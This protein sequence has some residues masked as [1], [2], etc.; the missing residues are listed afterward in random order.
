M[1]F[2][3]LSNWASSTC[4]PCCVSGSNGSPILR[5]LVLLGQPVDHFVVDLLLDEQPAAR[6]AALALVEVQAE[7]SAAMA[8]SRSASA[9]MTFGLLP[10]SSNV[11]RFSRLGRFPLD[12]LAPSASSPVK[13]ILSTPGWSHDG[14]AG[15]RAVAGHDVDHA[16]RN[17]GLLREPRHPQAGERRLLGRLHDDRATGRQRRAP[18]PGDHQRREVPGNDLADDADRLAPRVGEVI[19]A[20]RNRAALN[21]VGP[22]G[23]VAQRVDH[24]RN[25]G[26]RASLIGL[27]LSSVSSAANSSAS[28]S[29][30]SAS[31]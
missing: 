29:I 27:P 26:L 21:L 1:Y 12:D 31:L 15:G 5:R 2:R 11:S 8:A 7:V 20:D 6:T 17:A 22:A 16:V 25:V 4:G 23:V 10:P 14:G 19:A 13:A 24:Q 3:I 28:S 30:R 18:L 9:K